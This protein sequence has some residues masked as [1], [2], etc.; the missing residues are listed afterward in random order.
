MNKHREIV[1]IDT[2]LND[3]ETLL[4]SFSSDVEV[5]LLDPQQ[6]GIEQIA[7]YLAPQTQQNSDTPIAST[8]DGQQTAALP[9]SN[10]YTLYDAIHILSHGSAGHLYL[11]A[12]DLN[13]RNLTDYQSQL[14]QIGSAMTETG[15][16]LLYG[17]N[18]AEGDVGEQFITALAETT[19]AD[20]AA[21]NNL[22]G[23]ILLGGDWELEA[24]IGMIETSAVYP[25]SPYNRLLATNF[26]VKSTS[27][28]IIVGTDGDDSIDGGGG[29]DVID[30]RAGNDTLI[31]F[32]N[33]ANFFISTLEGETR[34]VGLSSASS[35]Y[36]YDEVFLT[37]VETIQFQDQTVTLA[38]ITKN[39]MVKTSANETIIGTVGNDAIDS[40][41]GNDVIDGG[42]GNDTLIIFDNRAN[43][44]IST[45]EG[46]TRL[47]GL[48]SASSRYSYDEVFLTNVEAIQFQDQTVTLAPITKN[49]MVKTSANETII[50]TVGNDAIDS[51]GGNDV[52]DGG[53]GNDTLI[54]FDNR[55]NFFI[56]TL[57][58][59][60]RLVGL[61]SA[62]SRY[63]YDEVFL[64][65]VETIQFQDQ[66]VTL[67]P[68]T[69]NLMVKTSAN[70]TI[71]GTVGNDAID[72]RGGNDVIDGGAGNDTLIIFDNRAN[73]FIS[74]LEGETRLVGLSSAS[75]R[76]SYDE[77]FLTN[78][79]A[80]QFQ[81][82][83]VTLAPI[84]KNLMVKTSAN[85][86]IIGTVGN[87]AID[88]RGGND[89][90]DGGAGNDTLIIFDNRANFFIA[91]LEGETR[92]VGLSS[93]SNR[94]SYDEVFLTNVEAIQFQDQTVSLAPITKNLMVKTSAN[95][96][97][98]GTVGNDAIDSRGGNDVI[99]G[100][101]GNDTLIIFDN[102]ANFFISTLE[103]ETRLVGL[104]SASEPAI[105]TMK[106]F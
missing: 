96:T 23:S 25:L 106:F 46:E 10:S 11:G 48:S 52:I 2:S 103:G 71:I 65:N 98:I 104:S 86:T 13:S 58:G 17:C 1:F 67:A 43:F 6:I 72:S 41:G 50:G 42:A 62:S 47:V 38:P 60:T 15:D 35:R 73:F 61:S 24:K 16:L 18:V 33:R 91:T 27:S 76:Y 34:L 81:D 55:A 7:A 79:E 29:N 32:D 100:G 56:S 19:G 74:T 12:T 21:S 101:A 69:K 78:V 68:I 70:E 53:A 49:L 44:F 4:A 59:E 20:V 14:Q 94:Y 80:I 75:S 77:V 90:I 9:V 36:S 30:G 97:I 82:Q 85:E 88:S 54:I 83:T 31:I 45:L 57:E 92:L 40:R 87:D 95:E 5:V 22:T 51:R 84:T 66:T 28:E 93:A 39:L 64:T 105:P 26:I 102:R 89:V 99:D 8:Q 63:S 37:N 3:W